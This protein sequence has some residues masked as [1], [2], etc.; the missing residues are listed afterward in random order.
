MHILAFYCGGGM[1]MP[2]YTKLKETMKSHPSIS[3]MKVEPRTIELP[4]DMGAPGL[5]RHDYH[6][7]SVAYGLSFVNVKNIILAKPIVE[8]TENLP[9][10]W[11]DNYIDKDM[12]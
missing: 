8:P 12:C 9:H 3:W 11:R 10:L 6:R 4:K 5:N 7:L 2:F 1:Q